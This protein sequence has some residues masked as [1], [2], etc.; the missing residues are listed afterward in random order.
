MPII[1][2]LIELCKNSSSII[3]MTY[4]VTDIELFNQK[5]ADWLIDCYTI[6]PH[7]S[8][9]MNSPVQ[10]LL[11]NR[12]EGHMLWTNTEICFLDRFTIYLV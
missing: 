7:H 12:N 11:K 2:D 5:M 6:I 9:Q 1:K 4:Y 3:T 8:L 10:Y